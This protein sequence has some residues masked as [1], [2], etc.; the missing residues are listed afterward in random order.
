MT[1]SD[2]RPRP[3]DLFFALGLGPLLRS[4]PVDA[5]SCLD[6]ALGQQGRERRGAVLQALRDLRADAPDEQSARR[7]LAPWL[8]DL[9]VPEGSSWSGYLDVLVER[10]EQVHRDP[11][12]VPSGLDAPYV[13]VDPGLPRASSYLDVDVANAASTYVV[14]ANE[15]L[16]RG[17]DVDQGGRPRIHVYADV[18]PQLAPG[19]PPTVGRV[20]AADAPRGSVLL[21]DG[22]RVDTASACLVMARHESGA[23]LILTSYPEVPLD[24]Q[25]RA[26]YPELCHVLGGWFGQDH[27]PALTAVREV[28]ATLAEP[29][30][31]AVRAE[32]AALLHDEPTDD[33]VRAVLEQC[34]SY[35]LPRFSRHWVDRFAW[36]L[37]AFAPG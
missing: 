14:R 28:T 10:A 22:A 2:F 5:G 9:E 1:A 6:A 33:G 30:R 12:L 20:V 35:L 19:A 17:W 15:A 31:S 16:I 25:V 27:E 3:L 8:D 21:G 11:S 32:L 34:G 23:P 7:A 26:R 24:E 36:R 37:G 4:A 29:A 18:T 13:L